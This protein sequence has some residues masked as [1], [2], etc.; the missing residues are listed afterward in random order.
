MKVQRNQSKLKLR[1]MALL[2]VIAVVLILPQVIKST[3]FMLVLCLCG[4]Y[5]IATA[6]LD[7]NFGY[8]G[9]ISLGHAAFYAIGAYGSAIL[10]KLAGINPWITML[11]ASAFAAVVGFLFA[12]PIS[13]LKFM[14]LSLVTTGFGEIVYQIIVNFWPDITGSTSG[15]K[16]IPKLGIA[17]F[18][19]K[20]RHD[21][22]YIVIFCTILFLLAKYCIVNS[23]IGRAF[24]AIRESAEAAGAMGINVTYYKAMSFSISAFYTAFA[25]ALYGHMVGFISPETFKRPQSIMLLTMALLGGRG[26]MLGPVIGSL[27]LVV[28]TESVQ[29][30]GQ[31]QQLIYGF[32]IIIVVLFM[33]GGLAGVLAS[34]K[35]AAQ[36]LRIGGNAD[37]VGDQ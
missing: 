34:A 24:I 31:Y 10:S 29:M 28:L 19:F 26:T 6:G 15:F 23:R 14:F 17:G 4:I 18:V 1:P 5:T 25:G 20:D 9:Q 11:L 13:K 37:A 22:A 27:I 2:L 7:I 8:A 36:N 16:G 30:F 3:Y 35:A 32:F 21:Y 12:L 33:P